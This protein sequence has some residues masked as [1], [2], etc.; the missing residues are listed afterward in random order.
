MTSRVADFSL[1]SCCSQGCG[2]RIFSAF[3]ANIRLHAGTERPFS[4]AGIRLLVGLILITGGATPLF[5][6]DSAPGARD[7]HGVD[8]PTPSLLKQIQKAWHDREERVHSLKL[9]FVMNTFEPAEARARRMKLQAALLRRMRAG[10]NQG[11]KASTESQ[12]QVVDPAKHSCLFLFAFRGNRYRNEYW[13]TKTESEATGL[14]A[15]LKPGT[16]SEYA[17]ILDGKIH[18]GLDPE[19]RDVAANRFRQIVIL[20]DANQIASTTTGELLLRLY[21]SSDPALISRNPTEEGRLT[22]VPPH[23]TQPAALVLSSPRQELWLDPSRDFVITKEVNFNQRHHRT[24]ETDC[25]YQKAPPPLRWVPEKWTT[26]CAFSDGTIRWREESRVLSWTT[27]DAGV[28]ESLFHFDFPD[29]TLILDQSQKEGQLNKCSI[30]WQGV[31]FP[32]GFGRSYV[33]SLE[34]VKAATSD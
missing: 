5:S 33:E 9:I 13:R 20:S 32:V 22:L 29:G 31:R 25:E 3:L 14:A 2:G 4:A 7:A 30:M 28:S 19:G 8:L 16:G 10:G 11:A 12:P 17:E 23:G 15:T 18:F 26:T 6:G 1:Q 24:C 21:R 27:G 34:L